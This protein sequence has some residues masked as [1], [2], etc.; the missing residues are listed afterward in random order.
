MAL[1]VTL[2]GSSRTMPHLK[3]TIQLNKSTNLPFVIKLTYSMD[4][5]F[6]KFLSFLKQNAEFVIVFVY[7]FFLLGIDLEVE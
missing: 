7:I 2:L 6:P 1:S 5:V 4:K 3:L